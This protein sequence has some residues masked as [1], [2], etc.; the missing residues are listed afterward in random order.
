MNLTYT[1]SQKVSECMDSLE[2]SLFIDEN[3][4]NYDTDFTDDMEEF[5]QIDNK[6][7]NRLNFFKANNGLIINRYFLA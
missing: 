6:V 5:A 2:Q 4:E 7:T 1:N 3:F